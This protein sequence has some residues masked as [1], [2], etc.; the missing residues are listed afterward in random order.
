MDL[1]RENRNPPGLVKY[2]KYLIVFEFNHEFDCDIIDPEVFII[3]KSKKS[4]H[5]MLKASKVGYIKLIEVDK[6]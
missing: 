5:E 6:W 3:A 1:D 2:K 4:A